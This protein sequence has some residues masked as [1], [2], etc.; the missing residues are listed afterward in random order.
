MN[1]RDFLDAISTH[2]VDHGAV[3]VRAY[4]GRRAIVGLR[5]SLRAYVGPCANCLR[6][7]DGEA[8]LGLLFGVHVYA[9]LQAHPDALR[10]E[11]E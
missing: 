2:L 10:M 3:P 4:L 5:A 11:G 1:L 7:L 8:Y 9:D 6:T